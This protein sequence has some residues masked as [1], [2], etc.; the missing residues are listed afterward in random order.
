MAADSSLQ[1]L[2]SIG[3][4][5]DIN[6][7]PA[8]FFVDVLNPKFAAILRGFTSDSCARWAEAEARGCKNPMK[9]W[10]KR[11]SSFCS[12]QDYID[13]P[14]NGGDVETV[15]EVCS[16]RFYQIA[17]AVVLIFLVSSYMTC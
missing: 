2:S 10:K 13:S 14:N 6:D 8:D 4:D 1:Y 3:Y 11:R 9:E 5:W 12:Q 15:E 7:N 17:V 16:D